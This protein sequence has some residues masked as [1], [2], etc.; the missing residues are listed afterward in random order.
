MT[1]GVM[2]VVNYMITCVAVGTNHRKAS[3]D[4]LTFCSGWAHYCFQVYRRYLSGS[5]LW[6]DNFRF[7]C[8]TASSFICVM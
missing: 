4:L 1:T 6:G 5:N 7:C 2:K 8:G 3:T